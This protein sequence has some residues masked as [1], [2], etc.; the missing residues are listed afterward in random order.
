MGPLTNSFSGQIVSPDP[1][2]KAPGGI[3]R[4]G[5]QLPV[6]APFRCPGQAKTKIALAAILPGGDKNPPKY[7]GGFSASSIRF[8]T[9]P[10]KTETFIF[11]G[12]L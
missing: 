1:P 3:L 9:A 2:E 11:L 5:S 12:P 4:N 10:I 8:W 7:F 6:R